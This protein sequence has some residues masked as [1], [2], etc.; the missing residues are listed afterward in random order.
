MRLT[1]DLYADYSLKNKLGREEM[2]TTKKEL[3]TEF[4]FILKLIY[5]E[6]YLQL[7]DF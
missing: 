6:Y 2:N 4:F 3:L 5:R 7:I 1:L